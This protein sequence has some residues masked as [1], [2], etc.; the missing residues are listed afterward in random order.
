MIVAPQ[1]RRQRAARPP[2]GRPSVWP[3]IL[4]LAGLAVLAGILAAVFAF[5]G[6]SGKL[7]SLVGNKKGSGAVKPV[8]LAG[9][10]SYDPQGDNK[11]EHPEAVKYAADGDPSTYWMTEHYNGGLGKNGVGVVLDAVGTKKLTQMTVTS[12][13]PGF[14]AEIEAGSS[15]SGGFTPVSKPQTVTG[16]TTF[17][18]KSADARYYVVW[19]TD[20]GANSSV[21]IDEVTARGR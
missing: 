16:R 17:P 6:S 21:Q 11:T 18:L 19:I 7:S 10:A 1:R 4:L 5:T 2:A 20:L 12:G 14:T 15:S 9:V 8:D 13:T 3:L